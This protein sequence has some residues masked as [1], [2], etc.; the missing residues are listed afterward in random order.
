[1]RV[2]TRAEDKLVEKRASKLAMNKSNVL[3]IIEHS[4]F[5]T[6]NPD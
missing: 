5:M 2:A 3:A 6:T 4:R 1:M